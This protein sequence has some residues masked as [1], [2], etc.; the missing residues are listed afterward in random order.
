MDAS[1]PPGTDPVVPDGSGIVTVTGGQVAAGTTTNVIR[2]NSLAANTYT[3]EV[4]RSQAVG[5]STI[6]DNGV[7]HF[8]SADF[9][10]DAN[11]FV[12]LTGSTS[13][14]LTG[15]TGGP[16]PPTAGNWDILAQPNSGSTPHFD[17]SVSTLTLNLADGNAN[18]LLGNSTGNAGVT[19]TF[20]S[21]LGFLCLGSIAGGNGN[22]AIGSSCASAI[23]DG[24]N[25]I[26][27]GTSSLALSTGAGSDSNIGI[28]VTTLNQLLS[29]ANNT[30]I[31]IGS[32]G[33]Y[34]GSESNN[35]CLGS[36]GILGENNTIHIGDQGSGVAQQNKCYIAGI[37]GVTASNA[38]FVTIDSVTGQLGVSS[39][40]IS[41]WIDTSGTFTAASGTGYFITAASTP[42][43]PAAPAQGDIVQFVCDTASTVTV[44]ANTGQRIRIGSALS[45]LAGTAASST[46]GNSIS[47][48]FRSATS[49]WFSIDA[50]EG[51]WAV[52]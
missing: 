39:S 11:G 44:T 1:T 19:G 17:G 12:S 43:L 4:Q 26:G 47:L 5:V 23:T 31:G 34:T 21:A 32:G 42:T 22:I 3:I 36:P 28:G 48:V 10:V 35:L 50:P 46:Q 51:T 33:N 2:T 27:I 41:T 20:N 18:I 30:A 38:Q 24:N 7:C 29:G 14:T 52:T 13:L 6:G 45:A 25:N 15:D 9:S 49:T 16:L 8:D 40:V 37:V